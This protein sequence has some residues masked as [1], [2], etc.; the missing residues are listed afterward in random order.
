MFVE[1]RMTSPARTVGP[2]TAASTAWSMMQSGGFH[3]LPVVDSN[4]G[5]LG[6][7]TD[8]DLR[9]ALGYEAAA[10][11]HLRVEEIMTTDPVCVTQ[12]ATL[13]EALVLLCTHR[14]GA[15][16][17]MHGKQLVGII[18]RS[19]LLRAFHDLLGL[20]S[21]GKRIEVAIPHGA[22]DIAVVMSALTEAD[23]LCSVVAARLRTDGSEP[24]LYLRTRARNP[25]D[26]EKRLRA[27]G[28]I[29]LA[30]ESARSRQS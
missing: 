8:R 17:V 21:P 16:P 7:V 20:E 3:Q 4:D 12:D 26:L 30:P 14:F 2:Q 10:H 23:E 11:A 18:T 25:W 22:A 27:K 28:A 19:D 24:V 6:I 15:L 9:S 1:N 5:L 29:L 13:E